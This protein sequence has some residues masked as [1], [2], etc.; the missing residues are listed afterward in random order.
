MHK[1]KDSISGMIEV[2]NWSLDI[3]DLMLEPEPFAKGAFGRVHKADYLGTPVCVKII[4]KLSP[5]E[6]DYF[7]FTQREVAALK[8][9]SHP[10]LVQF[11]G[12]S[13]TSKEIWIVTEFVS[14]G[15]VRKH[16]KNFDEDVPWHVRISIALDVASA[17]A[18]LHSRQIIHRDL[19]SKNLL[20]TD[21][22]R[23]KLC[24]FGFA[25]SIKDKKQTKHMTLCGTEEYMAP[26][27]IFGMSYDQRAEVYSFGLLM[28]EIIV[29]LK[30]EETIPRTPVTEF[31][32]DH[33][34]YRALV[35]KECPKEFLEVAL[36]CCAYEPKDR[37]EF[38]DVT[39]MLRKI[40]EDFGV[41]A[42]PSI[43]AYVRE[44]RGTTLSSPVASPQPVAP[45]AV[46]ETTVAQAHASPQP[47]QQ[48]QQPT[49][50]QQVAQPQ[51]QPQPQAQQT[52]S[53]PAQ[54]QQPEQ[55]KQAAQPQ[56]QQAVQPQ[57][58][59]QPQ[60]PQQA[61]QPQPQQ[62]QPQTNKTAPQQAKPAPTQQ[63]PAITQPQQ[64]QQDKK[65]DKKAG[66]QPAEAKVDLNAILSPPPGTKKIPPPVP[67]REGACC[68]L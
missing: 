28:C 37:P 36:K 64:Q 30:I 7:K 14:G 33:A 25:R 42:S 50:P 58:T 1:H 60:Q 66:K 56:P 47:Q 10:N 15:T 46:P 43:P 48:Q 51:P 9:L 26:E 22:W 59:A 63:S 41:P 21:N 54:A 49:Q 12:A 2:G 34:G 67:S 39:K 11:I 13:E 38:R 65:H 62:P 20:V 53:T 19:K 16:L 24:D 23:V 52:Q 35:P 61:A 17:M 32:L 5:D 6:D 29:R 4:S 8:S 18:F 44:N 45:A 3:K 68:V 27:V 40:K 57:Q 55:P 31:G